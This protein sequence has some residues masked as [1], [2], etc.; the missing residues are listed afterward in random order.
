MRLSRPAMLMVERRVREEFSMRSLLEGGNGLETRGC[1]VALAPALGTEVEV[2]LQDLACLEAVPP[3]EWRERI[4]LEERFGVA[5]IAALVA[6]GLLVGDD[7]ARATLRERERLLQD[8]W[9]WTPAAVTQVFSRWQG[10]DV[11][12]DAPQDGSRSVAGMVERQGLPPPAAASYRNRAE[13]VELPEPGRTA[14]DDL[15][16]ARSTCRN[17]DAAAPVRLEELASLLHRVFGAQAVT[18]PRP[19]VHMLKKNAPSGGGL[20]AIEAFVLAQ[21]VDGLDPGFY[22]YQCQAHALE[23]LAAAPEEGTRHVALELVAGQH[24]FADAPV[25]LLLA[26]RFQRNYWK[27][28]EHA[29]AWKVLQLDAGHLS[30]LLYLGATEMGYGA[31]ITAAINDECAE[32]LFELDGLSSGAIAVCGFGKRSGAQANLEFDPNGKAV[33]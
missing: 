23:P 15:L 9:W 3:R 32:R 30:Q 5:R 6:S 10:I 27:Y 24:W 16:A 25:L 4:E 21:R 18:E 33:R 8:T 1:W 17:F 11:V 29:K 28:R 7:E 26:A 12:A 31:F 14:L 19:G 13:W 20:H 2:D 22:H